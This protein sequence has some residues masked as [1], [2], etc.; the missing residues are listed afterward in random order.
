MHT[1]T[2]KGSKDLEMFQVL[3]IPGGFSYGDHLGSATIWSNELKKILGESVEE[4]LHSGKLVLGVCNGFQVL[5][6][7]GVLPNTERKFSAEATLTTNSSGKFESRW[8]KLKT[9]PKSPCVFT[10]GLNMIDMPVAHGEGNFT[11]ANILT[12]GKIIKNNQIAL[13]YVDNKGFPTVEYP[14]N[15]NG[16]FA[17]IAGISDESGRALG[18]MPHPERFLYDYQYKKSAE[19]NN[20]NGLSIYK[21]AVNYL[22]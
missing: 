13:Q 16:A 15:P 6:K 7:L 14:Q 12:F 9:N 17:S 18:L 8:V 20:V 4:F 2:I 21:N 5:V 22:K 11:P 3:I 1:S 19:R 10:K